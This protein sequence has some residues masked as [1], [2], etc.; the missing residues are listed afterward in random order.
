MG[1]ELGF[2]NVLSKLNFGFVCVVGDLFRYLSSIETIS[3][4]LSSQFCLYSPLW[5]PFNIRSRSCRD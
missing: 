3:A 2:V 5:L 1:E 4:L